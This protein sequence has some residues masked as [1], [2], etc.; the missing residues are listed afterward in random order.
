MKV[1]VFTI[2]DIKAESY[3]PPF[4]SQT[5][6]TGIRQFQELVNDH[7][8]FFSKYPEDYELYELGEYDDDDASFH[9]HEVKKT[10]VRGSDCLN[11]GANDFLENK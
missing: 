2:L 5:T 1:K 8:H 3:G 10:L 7:N 9:P 6:A 4:T 11:P